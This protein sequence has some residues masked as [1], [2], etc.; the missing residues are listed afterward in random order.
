MVVP[1]VGESP[2]VERREPEGGRGVRE[3]VVVVVV[4]RSVEVEAERELLD[5]LG[6]G[7]GRDS[8]RDA[9][10]GLIADMGG[11]RGRSSPTG[12]DTLRCGAGDP[13]VLA[14]VETARRLPSFDV[15]RGCGSVVAIPGIFCVCSVLWAGE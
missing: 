7:V 1:F 8:E 12:R 3:V 15:M 13:C 2:G 9:W 6:Y 10:F 14:C 4:G 5:P 11:V